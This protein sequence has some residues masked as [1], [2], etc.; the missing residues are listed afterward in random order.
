MRRIDMKYKEQFSEPVFSE[1]TTGGIDNS[2]DLGGS[3]YP[4]PDTPLVTLTPHPNTADTPKEDNWVHRADNM[5]CRTCMFFVRKEA[6][7]GTVYPSPV[8]RC[9]H[10]SP[11]M[12][13]WPVMFSTD[14]CGDHK[15]DENKL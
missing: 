1:K 11:T 2:G 12:K 6:A 5:R 13:G 8:G 9:R 4:G 10:R 3:S 15:L 7:P 14:W